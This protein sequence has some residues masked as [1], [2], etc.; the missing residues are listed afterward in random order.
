MLLLVTFDFHVGI[1]GYYSIVID[2]F[3]AFMISL[4]ETDFVAS[5]E[6]LYLVYFGLQRIRTKRKNRRWGKRDGKNGIRSNVSCLNCCGTKK[7]KLD[8]KIKVELK[9]W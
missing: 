7:Q 4:I 3:L 5:N 1:C 6:Q 9:K 2:D 8:P